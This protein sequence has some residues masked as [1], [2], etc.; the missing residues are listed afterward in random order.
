MKKAYPWLILASCCLLQGAGLGIVSNCAGVFFVPVM[1]EFGCSMSA[2]SLHVTFNNVFQCI[3]TLFVAKVIRKYRVRYLIPAAGLIV[4]LA[5]ISLAFSH[6]LLQWYICA[7]IQGS[8]IVYVTGIIIPLAISNWFTERAGF[9]LGMTAMSAGLAGALMSALFGTLITN[10][11]W[12]VAILVSGIAILVM[13]VPTSWFFMALEPKEKGCVPFGGEKKVPEEEVHGHGRIRIDIRVISIVMIASCAS[14][15]T[16]FNNHFPAFGQM[17]GVVLVAP[18]ILLSIN[19]FGNMGFKIG[20]GSLNDYIGAK[21][22]TLVS[23]LILG[24]SCFML[25]YGNDLLICIAAF[26]FGVNSLIATAQGPL[27]AKDVWRKSEYPMALQI[28]QISVRLSYA[29][30]SYV[31]GALFDLWGRYTPLLWLQVLSVGVGVLF[32]FLLYAG[33][34]KRAGI[35]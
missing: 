9:A 18:A 35:H 25:I 29:V 34:R 20:F 28:V 3:G 23:F 26:M 27:L 13:T 5:Q 17:T 22:T 31:E 24:C 21:R 16:I 1:E 10:A 32:V 2:I 14:F 19:M 11:S 30:F 7:V 12:R 4:G 15:S 33:R 8:F 6:S